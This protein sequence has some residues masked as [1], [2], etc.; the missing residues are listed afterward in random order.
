M[1]FKVILTDCITAKIILPLEIRHTLDVAEILLGVN[2]PTSNKHGI[3]QFLCGQLLAG[4]IDGLEPFQ[5][6]AFGSFAEIDRQLIVLNLPSFVGGQVGEVESV[7]REVSLQILADRD[8][9]LLS[10]NDLVSAI[11]PYGPVHHIERVALLESVDDGLALLVL[12]NKRALV[13]RADVEFATIPDNA[14]GGEILFIALEEIL[15]LDVMRL[16][17]HFSFL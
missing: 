9:P 15:N 16:D 6:L 12:V 11:R 10:V 8:S 7:M 5:F 13:L 2:N 14:V 4:N 17:I 3:S 1:G